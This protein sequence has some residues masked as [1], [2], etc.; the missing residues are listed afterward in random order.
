VQDGGRYV[1]TRGGRLL[2]ALAVAD[3]ALVASTDLDADLAAAARAPAAPRAP[4]AGAFRATVDADL[5]KDVLAA[6]LGL[7]VSAA[8]PSRPSAT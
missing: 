4:T 7:S 8:P 6:R 3:G 1:V 5:L 2:V